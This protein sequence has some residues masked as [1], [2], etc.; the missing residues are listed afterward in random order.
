M[1]KLEQTVIKAGIVSF[2]LLIGFSCGRP[3]QG[4][5]PPGPPGK[6][7]APPAK[8]MYFG[9]Y[10]N[11]DETNLQ[12]LTL[13]VASFQALARKP[14]TWAIIFNEWPGELHFPADEAEAVHAQGAIPFIRILPRSVTW[15]TDAPDPVVRLDRIDRGDFDGQLRE[16]ARD[17]RDIGFNLLVEFGPE[18][19]GFWNQWSGVH[20]P[21]GP[22]L[23]ASVVRHIITI[24]RAEGADNITWFFHMNGESNPQKPENRMAL[25]YP[26]DDYIDWIGVS[27]L[28]AQRVDDYWDE[29]EDVMD[30]AY[31]EIKQVSSTKPI[32]L[33]E[34][35]VVEDP[36]NPGHKAEWIRSALGALKQG[37]WPRLKAYSY[38]NEP[39]WLSVSN[40][41]RINSSGQTLDAFRDLA[42]DD[43]FVSTPVWVRR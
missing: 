23:Y 8:G 6:L 22:A 16:W 17:A 43:A 27:V 38:W 28:G 20:Y 39:A 3:P 15:Q 40:D 12:S 18:A 14:L 4:E 9:A 19:N 31:N 26:G 11:Y 7:L 36:K 37:R 34:T 2:F 41:L 32:A 25:F 24:C 1:R 5:A 21:N 35:G 29:F 10:G 33:V 13:S 30:K 42:E